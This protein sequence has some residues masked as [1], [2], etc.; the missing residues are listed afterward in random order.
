MNIH[1][2]Q[3]DGGRT[4]VLIKR[5]GDA[6]GGKRERER[7]EETFSASYSILLGISPLK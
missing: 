1:R 6:E 5:M 3:G 4:Q 2:F 7:E